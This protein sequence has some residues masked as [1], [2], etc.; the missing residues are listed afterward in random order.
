MISFVRVTLSLNYKRAH[1]QYL[2]SQVLGL[3]KVRNWPQVFFGGW[4]R[5]N[6][7]LFPFES[8]SLKR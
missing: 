1:Q 3:V 5:L 8:I 2:A 7:Q 6:T 4:G